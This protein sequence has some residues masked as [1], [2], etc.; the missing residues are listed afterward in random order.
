MSELPAS[1]SLGFGAIVEL[2]QSDLNTAL[3]HP[4]ITYDSYWVTNGQGMLGKKM[5]HF[6][7]GLQWDSVRFHHATLNAHNLKLVVF[8]F[9]LEFSI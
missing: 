3:W 4:N 9:F 7:N 2:N 5:I 6:V 8:Y 1:L